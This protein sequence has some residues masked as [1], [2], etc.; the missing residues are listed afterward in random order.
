MSRSKGGSDRTDGCIRKLPLCSDLGELVK[1]YRPHNTI[2]NCVAISVYDNPRSQIAMAAP[3]TRGP[4][5][6]LTP[7]IS[8]KRLDAATKL[9]LGM[10]SFTCAITMLYVGTIVAPSSATQT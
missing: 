2:S 3:A 6:A 5:T 9:L 8:S 10:T 7:W 1:R 4:T